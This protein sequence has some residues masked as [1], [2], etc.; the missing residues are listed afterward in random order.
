M[1]ISIHETMHE[2]NGKGYLVA[3]SDQIGRK[4]ISESDFFANGSEIE[5]KVQQLRKLLRQ[6][7]DTNP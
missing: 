3:I 2:Q 7:F 6:H 1:H 4:Q 5:T